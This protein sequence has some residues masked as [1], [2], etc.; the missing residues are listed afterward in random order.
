MI[1]RWKEEL[2][3]RRTELGEYEAANSQYNQVIDEFWDYGPNDH[4]RAIEISHR[5]LKE[6][7]QK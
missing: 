2:K 4:T 3:A 6:A 7:Q 1:A 5:Y